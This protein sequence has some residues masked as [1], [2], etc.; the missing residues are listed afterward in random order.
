M[1]HSQFENWYKMYKTNL[2]VALTIYSYHY[3][4]VSANF[5]VRIQLDSFVVAVTCD[6]FD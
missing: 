2:V 6:F 3:N 4:G 5:L 1:N